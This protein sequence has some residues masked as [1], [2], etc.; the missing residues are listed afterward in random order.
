MSEFNEIPDDHEPPKGG[1]T[2]G[3]QQRVLKS[4]GP[5]DPYDS[6][7]ADEIFEALDDD[8][9]VIQISDG[10]SQDSAGSPQ[11]KLC[12][13]LAHQKMRAVHKLEKFV[14]AVDRDDL[15]PFERMSVAGQRLKLQRNALAGYF[16]SVA[17]YRQNGESPAAFSEEVVLVLSEMDKLGVDRG[18]LTSPQAIE[19]TTKL[20][21]YQWFNKLAEAVRKG[22]RE[23][24]FIARRRRRRE[25]AHRNYQSGKNYIEELFAHYARLLVLRIDL[26]Y[27]DWM[28]PENN[29]MSQKTI[30]DIRRD[31]ARLFNNRRSNSIF[32]CMVGQIAK[33]EE[34]TTKGFHAHVMF[35]FDGALKRDD[36]YLAQSIGKYWELVITSG[37][38][39]FY[40][41]N[42]HKNRYRRLGI[43]MV[44]HHDA[45]KRGNLL[46]AMAYLTKV[47]QYLRIDVDG[48]RAFFRGVPPKP[49][50]KK[51]GRPRRNRDDEEPGA[52]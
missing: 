29:L 7:T 14:Q 3:E 34:G 22:L 19:Q 46:E 27:R 6:L 38:G 12:L 17:S 41:C 15:P 8:I 26:G 47:D 40:N 49:R 21:G 1:D 10:A 52:A 35:F 39:M 24:D 23:P 18:W 5:H 45:E 13:G 4:P 36:G 51:A 2:N 42:F 11:R 44:A 37:E 32:D 43:G 9:D 25:Q 48:G 30:H 20:A 16:N 28:R 33:I 50:V 31:V